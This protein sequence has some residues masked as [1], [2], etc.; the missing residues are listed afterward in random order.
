MMPIMGVG[1]WLKGRFGASSTTI[2]FEQ[3]AM[4]AAGYQA[5]FAA[6]YAGWRVTDQLQNAR[7]MAGI[8]VDRALALTVPAVLRGRNMICSVST[9]P[10]Q[11][12]DAQN[13]VQD[14]PLFKQIDP[15]TANVTMLAM[16]VEDLLF[17]AVAWWRA[18]EF[19]AFGYPVKAVRYAPETVSL[20]P[21]EDYL[22]GF[23]PSE[24][25][26][27][28]VI[29]ME[30]KPVPFAEVIRFDSPN[31]AF[32]TAGERA[33]RR[34]IA[35]DDAADLYATNR[36]M[37][38]FFTPKDNFEPGTPEQIAGMLDDFADARA[39]RIDGYVPG[40]L[41]YNQVQD[42]TPAEIQIIAQQNRA[43]LALANALGIDPEDLGIS[44]TSRTYQNAVDRRK[45]RIND[46]LSPYMKAITDRLTMPDVLPE[47]LSARFWLDDY[48]KADPKTRAEVQQIY[49]D[50]EVID[51]QDVQRAEGI[52][53]K[54]IEAP[55]PA[56][57]TVPNTQ[58]SAIPA[59]AR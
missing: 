22:R 59:G 28:G 16:L 10:L 54:Q 12:I 49:R 52:P 8:K 51:A 1:S 36:R 34:A 15:N 38:G 20:T 45:D 43:D 50:M 23:L 35:L 5:A 30:G 40:A 39:K 48:L 31:P 4:F 6:G 25:P 3:R 27:E 24:L 33:I 13:R 21:P 44:T 47:G 53:P 9:L 58:I 2:P 41:E 29:Y 56:R 19:D 37:R 55:E 26:T 14:H 57:P 32:L 11:A 18:I 42:P 17:D 46:V 7:A